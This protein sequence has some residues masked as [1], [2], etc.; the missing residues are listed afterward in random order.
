LAYREAHKAKKAATEAGQTVKIQTVAIEL[1]EMLQK[2]DDLYPEILFSE[3]R[4][5]LNEIDRRLRRATSPFQK[6]D[7]LAETITTLRT[8]L[9]TARNSLNS[10][11]PE[12]PSKEKNAPSAVYYAIQNDFAQINNTVADLL[13]LCEKKTMHFGG[14]NG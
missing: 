1:M 13:G 3:A 4:D 5:L 12:D 7:D 2:L 9:E 14:N 11:R 10:V 8:A 6:D